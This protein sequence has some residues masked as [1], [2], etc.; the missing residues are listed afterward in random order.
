MKLKTRKETDFTEEQC[1]QLKEISERNGIPERTILRLA[2]I[3][4]YRI[5]KILEKIIKKK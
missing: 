4:Y 3:Q 1:K 2:F 5:E